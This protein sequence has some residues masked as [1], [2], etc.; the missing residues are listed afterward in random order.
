MR[1]GI[2]GIWVCV[3]AAGCSSDPAVVM[4]AAPTGGDGARNPD[5]GKAIVEQQDASTAPGDDGGPLPRPDGATNDANDSGV[6]SE[7]GG[8]S[9]A[10]GPDGGPD[11]GTEGGTD[12]GDGAAPVEA[13][14]DGGADGGSNDAATSDASDAAPACSVGATRCQD[15]QKQTCDGQ[16]W[17]WQAGA[18]D[19]CFTTGRFT[20][21]GSDVTDGA[22]GFVW[23]KDSGT[24]TA[25]CAA[26]FHIPAQAELLTLVI[27]PPVNN[28]SVC[29]PTLDNHMWPNAWPGDFVASDGCV[30]ML[31]GIAR[32]CPAGTT[33]GFLCIKN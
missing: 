10:P 31:R 3:L 2:W 1:N 14:A 25:S 8:D 17:Q 7:G 26:G 30:D 23:Y 15:Y 24:G 16:T 29:S 4:P 28:V 6:Q 5:V 20:K 18:Q 27:G 32:T 22:T 13:G 11:G 19:C 9:A 21:V 12:G 33:K